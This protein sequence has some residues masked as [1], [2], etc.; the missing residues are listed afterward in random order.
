MATCLKKDSWQTALVS[1]N[2]QVTELRQNPRASTTNCL[3]DEGD[4]LIQ[5]AQYRSQIGLGE[6]PPLA[7]HPLDVVPSEPCAVS[8]VT[9]GER[10]MMPRAPRAR[11]QS[12]STQ[13]PS[14]APSPSG[15]GS[16]LA[17]SARLSSSTWTW[18]SATASTGC[19]SAMMPSRVQGIHAAGL[20][21]SVSRDAKRRTGCKSTRRGFGARVQRP[22]GPRMRDESWRAPDPRPIA[23]HRR[24][25][26]EQ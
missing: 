10:T 6:A 16:L 18:T 21:A 15:S 11:R 9:E 12:P 4:G 1:P 8:G 7:Q 23:P 20:C 14:G 24:R 22:R 3:G 13:L 2:G 25:C 19:D 26:P 17:E 5:I